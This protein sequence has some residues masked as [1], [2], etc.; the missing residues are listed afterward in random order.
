VEVSLVS[1]N[2]GAQYEVHNPWA[3]SDPV[4]LFGI[5]P[6]VENLNNK[7]IG[8]FRNFKRAATPVMTVVENELKK[9][10]PDSEFIWYESNDV[11]VLETETQNR[12]KF[13]S[14]VGSIDTAVMGVGD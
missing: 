5:N 9:K 14:W 6:R 1:S 4:P 2:T 3:E 7:K 12:E 13:E 11:N 8:I 10:Y